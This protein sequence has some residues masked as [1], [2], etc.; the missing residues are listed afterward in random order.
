MTINERMFT[1]LD[2]NPNKSAAELCRVLGVGTAQTSNWRK[3]GTDPKAKQL[4]AIANYLEV[5]IQYLVTGND[6][7]PQPLKADEREVLSM[8]NRLSHNHKQVIKTTMQGLLASASDQDV[9][10]A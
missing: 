7:N 9:A 10:T 8:Y 2:S 1:I 4:E 3:S 5:S 6:K